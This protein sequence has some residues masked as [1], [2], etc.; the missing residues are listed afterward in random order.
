MKRPCVKCGSRG[1]PDKPGG[2]CKYCMAVAAPPT[3]LDEHV[4]K[5][6]SWAANHGM[7]KVMYK[8]GAAII[9][10]CA[11]LVEEDI[12]DVCKASPATQ[13]FGCACAIRDH[14]RIRALMTE[15]NRPMGSAGPSEQGKP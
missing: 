5:Y 11:G 9:E 6:G 7:A 3:W 13:H 8:F 4:A 15:A 1:R 14:A 2:V 10:K 12:C